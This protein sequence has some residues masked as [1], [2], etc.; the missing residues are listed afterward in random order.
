MELRQ[1][2]HFQEIV[3]AASFGRAADALN[4]TQPALSKSIRNLEHSLGCQLLERHPSG[5]TPTEYGRVFLNYAALVTSELDRAVAELD[6]LRGRGRGV[7]RVGAG[8]TMLRYLLPQAVKRFMAQAADGASVSFRQGLKEELLAALRRGEIDVMVGSLSATRIDEDLHHEVVIADRIQVVADRAH[9]L[10]SARAI[11]LHQLAAAQWVLPE[12]RE[13]ERDRLAA[14]FRA[15]GHAGAPRVAVRTG[16][17]PFMAELLKGSDY[18]SYLPVA[19]IRL[20]PD[21]A[22][23]AA[24]DVAEPIWPAVSVG[25]T[26]RRRGVMLMPVRRFINRLKDVGVELA[27]PAARA[28]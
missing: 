6:A 16:S 23:L 18:L 26:Y 2:R 13:P 4:I 20:D 1:L 17:S 21:F 9:P 25:V 22:H 3:R 7:V 19:L 11:A 15:A 27:A 5:V 28:D 12:G 14:A 10:A 24:L 8:A